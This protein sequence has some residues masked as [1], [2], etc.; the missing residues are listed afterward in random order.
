MRRDMPTDKRTGLHEVI[1]L[2]RLIDKL[3]Q[4]GKAARA[5]LNALY[6]ELSASGVSIAKIAEARGQA[7][8]TIK[9]AIREHE[10][11]D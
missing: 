8:S 6:A 2:G 1:R 11:N 9:T 10:S 4:D 5:R 3:D 7:W